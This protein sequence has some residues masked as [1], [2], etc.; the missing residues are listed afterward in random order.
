MHRLM[1]ERAVTIEGSDF[2]GRRAILT[3][4][5]A[6]VAGWMLQY[7]KCGYAVPVDYKIA[8]YRKR[9]VTLSY[10]ETR[11]H[12]Y[13]HLG[14]LRYM[15]IDGVMIRPITAWLPY[16]GRTWEMWQSVKDAC[17]EINRPMHWCAVKE[18][19]RYDH[20]APRKGYTIIE[21]PENINDLCLE[22]SIMINFPGLGAYARRYSTDRLTMERAMQ[23]Y[24][25]GWPPW[26][27]HLSRMASFWPLSWPHHQHINWS[28]GQPTSVILPEFG[29][30]RLVDLLGTLSLTRWDRLLAGHV[31]SVCGG[32]FTDLEFVKFIQPH[33]VDI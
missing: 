2:F 30:H 21:P 10:D 27:R 3:I 26:L 18:V 4:N 32:H 11:A 5:P 12:V 17:L 13:E 16:Y 33:L 29:L 28:N 20:P 1:L 22:A 25:Q 19:L 31:T 6:K 9:R 14:A 15:G 24:T 7:T 23:V 8:V